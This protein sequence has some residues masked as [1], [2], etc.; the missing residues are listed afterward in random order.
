MLANSTDPAPPNR[1][2]M[3]PDLGLAAVLHAGPDAAAASPRIARRIPRGAF[4]SVRAGA[5]GAR[6][7]TLAWTRGRGDPWP[8][9]LRPVLDLSL[10]ERALADHAPRLSLRHALMLALA[11]T[12]MWSGAMQARN[13]PVHRARI[14]PIA[15]ER[16][17]VVT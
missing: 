7:P 15:I 8:A 14:V 9:R 11:A 10:L 17:H 5:R 3:T 6:A 16:G 2:W 13:R 4:V 1:G 12:V